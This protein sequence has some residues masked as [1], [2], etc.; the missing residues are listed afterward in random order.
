M[1]I[2]AKLFES[3][4]CQILACKREDDDGDPCISFKTMFGIGEATFELTYK[5]EQLRDEFFDQKLG[6]EFI[7][8]VANDAFGVLITLE[9]EEA[10]DPA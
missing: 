5:T 9:A 10:G 1:E 6:Q 7:D 8:K 2:W 3:H 4:G